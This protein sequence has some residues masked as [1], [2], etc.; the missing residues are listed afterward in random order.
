[1]VVEVEIGRKTVDPGYR[2]DTRHSVETWNGMETEILFS[3]IALV[4]ENVQ[5]TH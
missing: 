3:P 4:Q 1:M 2:K 5:I